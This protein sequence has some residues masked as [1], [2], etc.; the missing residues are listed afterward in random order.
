MVNV[1]KAVDRYS[2]VL[3]AHIASAGNDHRLGAHEAP[4]AI[5]SVFIG[6][7]LRA[8][9]DAIEKQMKKGK[10][11]ANGFNLN[12]NIPKIPEILLDNTDQKQDLTFCFYR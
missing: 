10:M 7:Q 8:T 11:N 6:S 2:N 5:I 3:R 12:I 9:L 1:L 4:P